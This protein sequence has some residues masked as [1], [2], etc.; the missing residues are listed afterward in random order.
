LIAMTEK[1]RSAGYTVAVEPK[2][3]RPGVRISM[4]EDPDGNWIELLENNA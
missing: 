2:D 4:I 3:V 1:C